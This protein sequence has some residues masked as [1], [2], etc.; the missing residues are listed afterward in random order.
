MD[1]VT[2]ADIAGHSDVFADHYANSDLAKENGAKIDSFLTE[3]SDVLPE[4]IQKVRADR[5][6]GQEEEEEAWG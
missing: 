5:Q 4:H 2:E 6:G 1:L 3:S